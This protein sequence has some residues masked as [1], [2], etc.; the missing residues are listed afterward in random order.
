MSEYR[1]GMVLVLTWPYDAE[2]SYATWNIDVPCGDTWHVW[3]RAMVSNS[4]RSFFATVDGQPN[5]APIFEMNCDPPNFSAYE[6]REL[7]WRAPNSPSCQYVE[8]PWLQDWTKG[9][10]EFTLTYRDST[11]IS[12]LWITN[13][14]QAPP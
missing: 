7:N 6:W 13:T 11:A 9:V 3:V 5:P 4:S 1:E 12:K 8:D 2:G 10:H 14:N